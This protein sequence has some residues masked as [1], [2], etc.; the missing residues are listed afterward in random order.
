MSKGSLV[1]KTIEK[2]K[3]K[4]KL[5]KKK[6]AWK[7]EGARVNWGENFLHYRYAKVVRGKKERDGRFKR[8][9]KN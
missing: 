1:S 3:S 6:D 4:R 8:I 5:D 7:M 9:K 2:R